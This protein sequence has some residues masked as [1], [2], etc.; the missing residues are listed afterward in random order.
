MFLF[1]KNNGKKKAPAGND[2][3]ISIDCTR[4]PGPGNFSDRQCIAC[5]CDALKDAT[6]AESLTLHSSSDICLRGES[7]ALMRDLSS[8]YSMLTASRPGRLGP[9]CRGC[10]HSF[11]CIV[12]EQ[13][14]N[15]PD[16]DTEVLKKK[17]LQAI[18]KS[19][20]CEI[21][22]DDTVRTLELIG[23]MISDIVSYVSKGAE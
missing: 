3:R 10:D 16:I 14:D 6:E 1:N 15:F 11:G 12:S 21:C 19:D 22:I 7:L 5:A 20:V 8:V 2:G 13:M 23:S 17:A 9:R 4:C 18:P